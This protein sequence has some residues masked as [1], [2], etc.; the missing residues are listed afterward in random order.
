MGQIG[1]KLCHKKQQNGHLCDHNMLCFSVPV[2]NRPIFC[3]Y[4]GVKVHFP[5]VLG[6][7]WNTLRLV[8]CVMST[9]RYRLRLLIK[10]ILL[11]V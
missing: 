1:I 8:F 9:T 5:L 6:T 11:V 3:I 2:K 10:G 4:T 7:F